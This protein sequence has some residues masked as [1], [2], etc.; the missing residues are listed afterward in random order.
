MF[1]FTPQLGVLWGQTGLRCNEHDAHFD[2]SDTHWGPEASEAATYLVEVGDDLIQ[3]TQALH[4]LV[5]HLGLRVKVCEPRD[6]GEHHANGIVR[7]GI[8]LLDRETHRGGRTESS[9]VRF[10]RDA[11]RARA[12]LRP[13]TGTHGQRRERGSDTVMSTR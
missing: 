13:R 1:V 11:P 2:K 7:L 6:G 4:S 5:I 10:C 3:Q 9:E 12:H 8:Q